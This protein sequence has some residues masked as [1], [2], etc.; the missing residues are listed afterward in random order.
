MTRRTRFAIRA[1][2]WTVGVAVLL[3]S[4]RT[5]Q[6]AYSGL[7]NYGHS[8]VLTRVRLALSGSEMV[9][10]VLFLIPITLLFGAYALLT[11]FSAAI[12][13]HVLHGDFAGVEVLVLY[14]VAVWLS[15]VDRKDSITTAQKETENRTAR[16]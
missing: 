11:I 9:A 16:A 7:H 10:A 4:Y 14:G 13:I 8:E 2:H 3:A 6:A 1:L 15:L 5:F 12:L